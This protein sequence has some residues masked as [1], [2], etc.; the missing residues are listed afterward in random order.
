MSLDTLSSSLSVSKIISD[1]SPGCSNFG[2]LHGRFV[3]PPLKL[4]FK[5]LLRRKTS[6][7]C[8]A[9]SKLSPKSEKWN[10]ILSSSKWGPSKERM[11]DKV[12]LIVACHH[13]AGTEVLCSLSRLN[14]WS[15]TSRWIEQ[16]KNKLCFVATTSLL[17]RYKQPHI[18]MDTGGFLL[19]GKWVG[20]WSWKKLLV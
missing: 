12:L 16:Q 5:W 4:T 7:L 11:E 8:N 3:M 15:F 1:I 17:T 20:A 13:I 2:L 9:G 10:A 19:R 18:K 14:C 6:S